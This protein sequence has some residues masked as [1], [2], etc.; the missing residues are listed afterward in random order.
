MNAAHVR[1]GHETRQLARDTGLAEP[2]AALLL[3]IAYACGLLSYTELLRAASSGGCRRRRM[4]PG[5]PPRCPRGIKL[6]RT[7]LAMTRAP[8]TVG[9]RDE[10]DRVIAAFFY[11]AARLGAPA[12]RRSVLA[13][14]RTCR[15]RRAECGGRPDRLSWRALRRMGWPAWGPV[16]SRWPGRVAR[17]PPRRH[18]A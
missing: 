18:R 6:A 12:A 5:A 3:E 1:P 8:A 16:H 2:D 11:E 13:E 7:W 15:G 10:K 14:L 4:T 17:P 9:L